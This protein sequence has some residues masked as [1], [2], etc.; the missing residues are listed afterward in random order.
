VS[1]IGDLRRSA[2]RKVSIASQQA[3]GRAVET[4]LT[5]HNGKLNRLD[6]LMDANTARGSGGGDA[7]GS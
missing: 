7:C 5:V 1:K 3:V 4:Y 6:W 2:S